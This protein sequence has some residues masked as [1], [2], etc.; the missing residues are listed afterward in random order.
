M[1]PD[2]PSVTGQVP[3][4]VR[5]GV[6][7]PDAERQYSLSP[8]YRPALPIEAIQRMPPWHA[9]LWWQSEP[10]L[11]VETRPA[12]LIE[13]YQQVSGYTPAS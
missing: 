4:V 7:Y 11:H 6:I 2:R 1:F 13:E 5:P 8:V 12:G 9:W 3:G 10:P